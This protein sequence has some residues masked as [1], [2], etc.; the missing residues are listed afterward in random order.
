MP[1]TVRRPNLFASRRPMSEMNVTRLIDVLLVLIIMLIVVVPIATHKTE[2]DLPSGPTGFA[3]PVSNTVYI[4]NQ[5][6]LFWNGAIVTR[7]QLRAN[8]EMASTMP[9]QPLLRFEPDGLASYDLSAK[10]IALIKDSGAESF[11]FI[12]NHRHRDFER[13]R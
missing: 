1:N 12:G 4:D 9:E 5:G 6:Q 13:S 2:V 10:T 11:A 7:E 8:I 3:D